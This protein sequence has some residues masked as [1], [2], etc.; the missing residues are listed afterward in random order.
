MISPVSAPKDRTLYLPSNMT[1]LV[2]QMAREIP[3]LDVTFPNSGYRFVL[4][5]STNPAGPCGPGC[6]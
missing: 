3:P 2:S 4:F 5:I 1:S 6:P